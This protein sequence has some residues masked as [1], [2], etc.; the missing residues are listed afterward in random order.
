[1]NLGLSSVVGTE[2]ENRYR[3]PSGN[4][5]REINRQSRDDL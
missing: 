5:V 3:L 4:R 1:M 2:N